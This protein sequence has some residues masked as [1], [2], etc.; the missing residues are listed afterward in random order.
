MTGGGKKTDCT[1]KGFYGGAA[2]QGE[3]AHTGLWASA[4]FPHELPILKH[5]HFFLPP[6]TP[7]LFLFH[8]Q[9]PILKPPTPSFAVVLRGTLGFLPWPLGTQQPTSEPTKPS[10]LLLPPNAE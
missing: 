8:N 7:N 3:P 6:S 1:S 5:S 4:L 10:F 9:I 2:S